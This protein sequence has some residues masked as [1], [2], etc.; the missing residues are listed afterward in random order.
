[1]LRDELISACQSANC[2]AHQTVQALVDVLMTAII[3]IAPTV[4][5]AERDVTNITEAMRSNIRRAYFE[6]HDM[7]ASQRATWQ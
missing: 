3:A 4:D 5:D 6:Y 7:A 2:T 1:M